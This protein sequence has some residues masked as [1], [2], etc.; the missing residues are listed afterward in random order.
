MGRNGNFRAVRLT[1]LLFTFERAQGAAIPCTEVR[2]FSMT[3]GGAA[4]VGRFVRS[5]LSKSRSCRAPGPNRIDLREWIWF[6]RAAHS[7]LVCEARNALPF[8]ST[9]T[10]TSLAPWRARRPETSDTPTRRVPATHCGQACGLFSNHACDCVRFWPSNNPA[11]SRESGSARRY[12]HAR[13]TRAPRSPCP[14]AEKPDRAFRATTVRAADTES[15]SHAPSAARSFPA[16]CLW[17]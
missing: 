7:A 8:S 12:G 3:P 15:P 1:D 13:S 17:T 2:C 14:A 11:A 4:L 9:P 5:A 6:M 10:G 16:S